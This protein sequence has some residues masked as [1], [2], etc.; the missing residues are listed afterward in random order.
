MGICKDFIFYISIYFFFFETEK[1]I[2]D[3]RVGVAWWEFWP[4]VT[5]GAP[6]YGAPLVTLSL[7]VPLLHTY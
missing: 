2:H 7:S 3:G 1:D 6:I 5:S 4:G